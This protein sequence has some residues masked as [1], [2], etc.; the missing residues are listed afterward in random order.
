MTSSVFLHQSSLHFL[1]QHRWWQ[2]SIT[3][4]N[5]VLQ[6]RL[7][8]QLCA[9]L[10]W[11]VHW[12]N[13]WPQTELVVYS[14]L[15]DTWRNRCS[16]GVASKTDDHLCLVNSFSCQNMSCCTSNI[17]KILWSCLSFF[18]KYIKQWTLVDFY[19]FKVVVRVLV[20]FSS[21]K[22]SLSVSIIHELFLPFRAV[23]RC[24]FW[25]L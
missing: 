3:T 12:A 15:V 23:K 10:P 4:R 20:L 25:P 1:L 11:N 19:R 5:V 16:C 9:P 24:I 14:C 2:I 21:W 7:C 18:I 13:H 8:K 6:T 22:A 17:T